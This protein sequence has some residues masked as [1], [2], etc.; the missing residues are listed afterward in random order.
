VKTIRSDNALELCL[1]REATAFFL[2]KGIIHQTSC[3][4]QNGVVERKHKHL[5][6]TSRALLFHSSLPIKCWGECIFTATYLINRFPS[7]VIKG[8]SPFQIFFWDKSLTMSTLE[9]LVAFAMIIPLKLEEINS[10]QGQ[11]PVYFWGIH[12]DRKLISFLTLRHI[13]SSLLEMLF[14]MKRCSLIILPLLLIV[15][16]Y[17][18]IPSLLRP[19]FGKIT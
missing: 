8:A 6:E 13:T 15:P 5:L 14:F 1:N 16:I 19:I 10:K 11:Y 12:L 17:F 18:D 9:S 2:S 7:K 3:P 4:Q